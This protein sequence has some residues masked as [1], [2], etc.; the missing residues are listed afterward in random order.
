MKLKIFSKTWNIHLDKLEDEINEFLATL[1]KDDVHQIQT[2]ATAI[3][4][5]DDQMET[6][7]IVTVWYNDPKPAEEGSAEGAATGSG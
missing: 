2:T 3:R 1:S 5:A 7:Y 4:S 6:E